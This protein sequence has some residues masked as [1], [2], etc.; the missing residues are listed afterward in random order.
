VA[1]GEVQEILVGMPQVQLK[2]TCNF[3]EL[4]LFF[5]AFYSFFF[6]AGLMYQHALEDAQ[7]ERILQRTAEVVA[8]TN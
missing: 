6:F 3:I 2:S 7:W 4:F 5:V 1:E 8:R